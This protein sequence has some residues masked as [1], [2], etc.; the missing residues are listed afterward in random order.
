MSD[1]FSVAVFRVGDDALCIRHAM[2]IIHG[3]TFGTW[4][5]PHK[6]QPYCAECLRERAPHNFYPRDCR[7]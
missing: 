2:R 6:P 1:G 7:P 4:L 5:D 3:L